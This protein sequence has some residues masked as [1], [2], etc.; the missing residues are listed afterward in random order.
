MQRARPAARSSPGF[1]GSLNVEA[2]AFHLEPTMQNVAAFVQQ[3]FS[4]PKAMEAVSATMPPTSPT[5]SLSEGALDARTADPHS[6]PYARVYET[7]FETGGGKRPLFL[8]D[9]SAPLGR[10]LSDGCSGTSGTTFSIG[11]GADASKTS[12]SSFSAGRGGKSSVLIGSGGGLSRNTS[13]SSDDGVEASVALLAL[14]SPQSKKA[15]VHPEHQPNPSKQQQQRQQTE[16]QQQQQSQKKQLKQQELQQPQQPHKQQQQQQQQQEHRLQQQQQQQ[17][18]QHQPPQ[19][20]TQTESAVVHGG[21]ASADSGIKAGR[22][23]R[24]QD[25]AK[26]VKVPSSP[27][28]GNKQRAGSETVLQPSETAAPAPSKHQPESMKS[29]Q[30]VQERQQEQAAKKKQEQQPNAKAPLRSGAASA[31]IPAV[32]A[33][34]GVSF[35]VC[36]LCASGYDIAAV[37]PCGHRDVCAKCDLKM[38]TVVNDR[39]C[40]FCKNATDT[41]IYAAVERQESFRELLP[42]CHQRNDEWG[43]VFDCTETQDAVHDLIALGCPVCKTKFADETSLKTHVK[44]VHRL[45]YCSV[46]LEQ[47]TA[48][49]CEQTLYSEADLKSHMLGHP[50][51]R[52]CRVSFLDDDK[53]FVHMERNH[54][55]CHLCHQAGQ[56]YQYFTNLDSFR[57]HCGERHFVCRHPECNIDQCRV[58]A[59]A[60]ELADHELDHK[61]GSVSRSERARVL[62]VAFWGATGSQPSFNEDDVSRQRSGRG[63]GGNVAREA[64]SASDAAAS[65]APESVE[66]WPGLGGSASFN[67]NSMASAYP[68][69][70]TRQ[71]LDTHF[72]ALPGCE[73]VAPPE[74]HRRPVAD[75]GV[76]ASSEVPWLRDLTRPLSPFTQPDAMMKRNKDLAVRSVFAFA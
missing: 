74:R 17:E 5:R 40:C 12:R 26:K 23:D 37:H 42:M 54:L 16:Q 36:G 56:V 20:I 14:Q 46:C 49:L 34:A 44:S 3:I 43:A 22:Q 55:R 15:T 70:V 57:V 19:H 7:V 52:F 13:A 21:S 59:S 25:Q 35:H 33:S 30:E 73:D 67:D 64:I 60:V 28:S 10:S 6:T 65:S 62:Q 41:V 69:P 47:R 32:E 75:R 66:H 9:S 58:F 18:H 8:G 38:R 2:P 45:Q 68:P 24:Q 31:R 51:C 63:R 48:L 50:K 76:A 29:K 71:E 72:P 27:A 61:A 4:S 1:G 53:L 11:G 39:R